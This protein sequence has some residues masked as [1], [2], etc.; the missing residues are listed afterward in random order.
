MT[1]F[2]FIVVFVLCGPAS[3]FELKKL[4]VDDAV[5]NMNQLIFIDARPV[6]VWQKGHIP[7]ALSFS[8]ESYTRTD[9][10]GVKYRTFPPEKLAGALGQMG[11]SHTA[12]V[13]VY[14]DADTS[15]GGEG[16]VVWVFAWLGHQGTVYAL[17]GGFS[18]WQSKK[19]P[20]ERNNEY[21]FSGTNYRIDLQ[22]DQHI[23]AVDI[24][25]AGNTINLIDTR[26]Y[27]TEWLP[28]HLSGAVHIPWEKF[29]HGDHRRFLSKDA[30]RRLLV[31][32]GVD[33]EKPVVYYCTGGIRSGFTWM[34]HELAGL[35][36]AKNFEGGAEEW[37][38]MT[39]MEGKE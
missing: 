20:V 9:A 29:Y 1:I 4:Q 17:D 12:A 10:D 37:D 31:D 16:W 7:K 13:V 38:H 34:I 28:G 36:S 5:A 26:N 14:G 30:L 6:K 33:L 3:G 21:D 8:W 23:S 15:W 19:F 27:L 11:I 2:S 35:G 39:K 18:L 22:L 32:K 25:K 24:G